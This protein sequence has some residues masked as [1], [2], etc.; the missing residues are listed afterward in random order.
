[1]AAIK[2]PNSIKEFPLAVITQMIGLATSGFGLVVALAWNEFIKTAVE[3]YI[4]PYLGKGSG[5]A[6]LFIYAVVVTAL[7]VLVTMQLTRMQQRLEGLGKKVRKKG[8]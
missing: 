5:V 1:M 2:P 6:S 3:V 7:A 8:G 4:R